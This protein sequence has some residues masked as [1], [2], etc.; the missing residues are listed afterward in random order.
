MYRGDKRYVQG[1]I[2][3]KPV[4]P[5]NRWEHIRLDLKGIGWETRDCT[6]LNQNRDKW[7]AVVN[8][9]IHIWVLRNARNFSTS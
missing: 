6:D 1:N 2:R 5:R 9:V 3:E 8:M 4:R 7:L